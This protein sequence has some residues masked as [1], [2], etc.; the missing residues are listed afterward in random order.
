MYEIDDQIYIQQ[1]LDGDTSSYTRLVEKYKD[2]VFTVCYR[3]VRQ[4]EDA[5]DA[6]QVVFIKAFKKLS[7]FK[8]DSKFSTWLYTIAYRTAIANTKL[9][10]IETTDADFHIDIA[11]DETFPQLE[12]MKN[13]E[14]QFYVQK[15]IDALP[16][17]DS[18]IIS[19]FY[20]DECSIQE[21]VDI[22]ELKESNV[23][24]KLHRARKQLKTNLESL[25]HHEMKSII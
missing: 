2:M 9:K 8:G 5:E 20:I 6:A 1:V 23:K 12:G 21:I 13:K 19:L 24:V 22:T 18:V 16:E 15:A 14:Q 7:S 11:S 10:K 25:L 4:K 3:I 17:I